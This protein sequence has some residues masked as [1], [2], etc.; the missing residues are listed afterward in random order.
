MDDIPIFL[1]L[2]SAIG[3]ATAA[4]GVYFIIKNN[5]VV[6]NGIQTRAKIVDYEVKIDNDTDGYR[7][8]YYYPIIEF[9]DRKGNK[10]KQ[11]VD[12]GSTSKIKAQTIEIFYILEGKEYN[13]VLNTFVFRYLL[14]WGFLVIGAF[15]VLFAILKYLEINPLDW[16]NL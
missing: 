15:F 4:I 2:F 5:R 13:I 16:V 1:I 3:A 7:T 6:K 11:K 14:P 8:T 10:V 12:T 9:I